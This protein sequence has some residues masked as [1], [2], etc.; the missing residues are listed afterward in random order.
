MKNVDEVIDKTRQAEYRL[1]GYYI[2]LNLVGDCNWTVDDE[3]GL[4]HRHDGPAIIYASGLSYSYWLWGR[5]VNAREHENYKHLSKEEWY[6]VYFNA[7][8]GDIKL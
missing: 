1:Q 5:C 3:R 6:E 4:Y 8:A 7:L 2:T